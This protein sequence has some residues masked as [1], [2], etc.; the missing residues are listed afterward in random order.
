ML[1][2]KDSEKHY[3]VEIFHCISILEE[4]AEDVCSVFLDWLNCL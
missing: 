2:M 4:K 1:T 3:P